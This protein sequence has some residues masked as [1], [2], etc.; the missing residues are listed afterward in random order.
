VAG[1]AALVLSLPS[2]PA[3]HTSAR[4]VG[5]AIE[6]RLGG[7][8]VLDP[9]VFRRSSMLRHL[10]PYDWNP[11]VPS[12]SYGGSPLAWNYYAHQPSAPRREVN[13][14][15][16]AAG[17]PPPTGARLLV[18]EEG[19]ALYVRSDAVWSSH[20]AIRPPTPAGS[21]LYAVPRGIL[22]RSVPLTNGP[23]IINLVDV[24][25]RAGIDVEPLLTRLG[26]KR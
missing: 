7:Y 13:Y 24:A 10:F 22:F 12:G 3:P 14:V 19:V 20:R 23:P 17:D 21:P 8:E 5:S 26:V 9:A 2:D 4:L 11:S 6:D 15:L 25:E 16:Q 1:V 18:R